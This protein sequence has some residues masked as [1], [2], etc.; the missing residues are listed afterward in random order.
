MEDPFEGIE[1]FVFVKNLAFLVYLFTIIGAVPF[2]YGIYRSHKMWIQKGE[3]YSFDHLWLRLKRMLIYGLGNKKVLHQTQGGLMHIILYIGIMGLF[4]ATILSGI[5]L[6]ITMRFFNTQFLLGPVYLGF[7]LM[8]NISG[9]LV[10]IGIGIALWRRIAKTYPYLPTSAQDYLILVDLLVI[11]ATGFILDGA[12]TWYYRLQ[13][14]DH[15]DLVGYEIALWLKSIYGFNY[16]AFAGIYTIIWLIHITLAIWSVAFIPYTKLYHMIVGGIFNTFFSRLEEPSAFKPIKD[17]DKRIEEN[18]PL[19]ALAIKDLSWKQRM[20][21]DA[22]IKCA[23]CTNACPANASGKPLN[24]MNL[25]Q[26]LKGQMHSG[27][28]E[29]KL[30][31][32]V[33]APQIIWSCTTCGAC[34]EECPMLIHH[35]ETILDLRR[36]V[37]SIGENVPQ[38]LQQVSY[39]IMRVGNPY[40]YDPLE[41]SK[42]IEKLSN[43]LGIE[44]AQE[45]KEYDYIYWLGCNAS[46]DPNVQKV[47]YSLLKVLRKAGINVAILADE[48]CCGE[49]ARRIGDEYLF[50]DIVLK[51]T[52]TL[53]RYKFKN[54]L[55]SCPHGYNNFKKEYPLYSDIK[56]NVVHHSQ[57]LSQLIKEGEIKP[58]KRLDVIVTYHDPCY[59]ARWNSITEDPREVIKEVATLKEM[60]RVRQHTFCCG[61]GG[62]GAF[63]DIKIGERI[64]KLRIKEASE[65]GAKKVIVACPFCNIMLRAEAPTYNLEVMDIAELLDKATE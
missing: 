20:D 2:C 42:F 55:V 23:R 18:K 7:K 31:P 11:V 40:G 1:Y 36:G 59:L 53:K 10:I 14:I 28:Y 13:W 4:L 65:T 3:F 52:E 43:E 6:E 50:R 44:I 26:T 27:K 9:I 62:G 32:D 60:K 63:Y 5:Q 37:Y 57:L 25:I 49:P 38:E 22:C 47:A 45:G 29:V 16:N 35:V 12:N 34:V 51:T 54:L 17:M 19:G 30:I 33:I 21:F 41:R 46:Y 58:N 61:G 64:S 48:A 56:L 24:P 8:A 15:Y 39:N